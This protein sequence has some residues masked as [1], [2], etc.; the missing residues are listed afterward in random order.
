MLLQSELKM[1]ELLG[2]SHGDAALPSE[3]AIGYP[4]FSGNKHAFENAMQGLQRDSQLYQQRPPQSLFMGEEAQDFPHESK[5][6]YFLYTK[7]SPHVQKVA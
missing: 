5:P 2:L 4:Q 7:N 3:M 1:K 6:D